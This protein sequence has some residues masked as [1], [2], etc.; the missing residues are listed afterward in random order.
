L[1]MGPES[2]LEGDGYHKGRPGNAKI[3]GLTSFTPRVIAWVATQVYFAL[4][5]KQEWGK[6]DG[7]F[8]YE[9]FFWT[10]HDLFDSE[11]WGQEIIDLWNRCVF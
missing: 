8:D 2:A 10:I 6:N 5:S 11:E 3:I 7:E 9:E 4:S 1:L